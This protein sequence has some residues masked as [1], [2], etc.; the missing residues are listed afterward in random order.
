MEKLIFTKREKQEI[1][2]TL[3]TILSDLEKLWEIA[4]VDYIVEYYTKGD[5]EWGPDRCLQIDKKGIKI[6]SVYEKIWLEKF[7][8]LPTKPFLKD[9]NYIEV[10]EFLRKYEKIRRKIEEDI[11]HNLNSKEKG[12]ESLRELNAKYQ[13]EA[14]IEVEI[15]P[16]NNQ[17]T[18]DVRQEEGKTIGEIKMG[19][20]IF[21]IITKGNLVFVNNSEKKDQKVK[22]M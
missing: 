12:L 6:D 1:R 14:M 4:P 2:E 15:P 16:S 19:Y 3:N 9:E 20:G 7:L 5:D 11:K 17:T 22:K 10:F 8:P 18:I 21:R 13:K